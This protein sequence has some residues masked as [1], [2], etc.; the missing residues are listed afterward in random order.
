MR[1]SFR[2]VCLIFCLFLFLRVSA[3]QVRI[4]I[5]QQTEFGDS[6]F[7]TAE[8]PVMGFGDVRKSVKLSPMN[9]PVWD[10]M[11]DLPPGIEIHPKFY[12]R[13]DDPDSLPDPFNGSLV[14]SNQTITTEAAAVP[15]QVLHVYTG[16]ATASVTAIIESPAGGFTPVNLGLTP[17][18]IAGGGKL[19]TTSI[20]AEHAAYGRTFRLLIGSAQWPSD[21]PIALH[22]APLWLRNGQLFLYDPPAAAPAASR[23]EEFTFVPSNFLGRR[24]RVM[25]PRDYD[26]HAE[27]RYPVLFAQDGQNVISPGGP[28][29]SWDLDITI[30][31]LIERGE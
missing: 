16:G 1:A 21:G 13:Q 18:E 11:F 4:S 20:P 2:P 10:A 24:I 31:R 7:V 28:F 23:I 30:K 5:S 8:I 15:P 29:G 17:Q 12:V 26:R 3:E 9:Y 22:G 6:V 19:F 14:P 27:T 25:L